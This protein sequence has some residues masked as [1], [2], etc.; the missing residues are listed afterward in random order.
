MSPQIRSL[1]AIR[2]TT[3]DLSHFV[4]RLISSQ[5]IYSPT[6]PRKP[7]CT[8]GWRDRWWLNNTPAQ[9]VVVSYWLFA[10]DEEALTAA[11]EGRTRLSAQTVLINGRR[12]SIYQPLNAD[13]LLGDGAWQAHRNYLFA[14]RNLLVL[15]AEFGH[16][17]SSQTTAS[18]AQKILEKIDNQLTPEN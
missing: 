3:D 17:V 13:E 14:R 5:Q 10:S 2:L 7:S 9:T 15:V 18:I 1:S 4:P 6:A 16:Q 12:E 11:T 8:F